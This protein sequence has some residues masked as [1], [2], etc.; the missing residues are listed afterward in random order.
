MSL[1]YR[2]KDPYE[3]FS[4]NEERIFLSEKMLINILEEMNKVSKSVIK[5]VWAYPNLNSDNL[6]ELV[7]KY[8]FITKTQQGKNLNERMDYC[9]KRESSNNQKT[10]IFDQTF[11]HLIMCYLKMLSNL[12]LNMM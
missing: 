8:N 12:Y 5:N 4:S 2:D 10:I 6:T 9:L 1:L 3:K 11:Q 7:D